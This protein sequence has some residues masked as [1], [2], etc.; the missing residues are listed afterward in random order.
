MCDIYR[1]WQILANQKILPSYSK[2]VYIP[3]TIPLELQNQIYSHNAGAGAG[4]GAGANV[5]AGAPK[6]IDDAA[7]SSPAARHM[8]SSYGPRGVREKSTFF[9]THGG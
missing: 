7:S 6:D 3:D 4:A 1:Y 8:A 9:E 2:V 5:G